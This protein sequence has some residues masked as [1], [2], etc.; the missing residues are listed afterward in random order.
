MSYLR[1]RSPLAPGNQISGVNKMEGDGFMPHDVFS[2]FNITWYSCRPFIPS[3]D[4]LIRGPESSRF[5]ESCFIN[6]EELEFSHV[7]IL[8]V[9]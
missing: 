4:H 9:A 2:W 7:D 1:T 6:F 3:F 5:I 8:D